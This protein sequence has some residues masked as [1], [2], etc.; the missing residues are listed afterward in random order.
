MKVSPGRFLDYASTHVRALRLLWSASPGGFSL[1]AFLLLLSSLSPPVSIWLV[2]NVVDMAVGGGSV[3]RATLLVGLWAL[4]LLVGQLSTQSMSVLQ[5]HLN[6]AAVGRV[7]TMLLRKANSLPD[8]TLFEN[9]SYYDRLQSLTRE[10]SYRPVNLVVTT[11]QLMS[12]GLTAIGLLVLTGTLAWWLPLVL[13]VTPLPLAYV[14]MRLMQQS[15]QVM[16]RRSRFARLMRYML[17]VLTTDEHAKEVRVFDLGP[18]FEERYR[19][20]FAE[21]HAL[22]QFERLRRLPISLVAVLIF[23]AGGVVTLGWVVSRALV[24]RLSAGSVVLVLQSLLALQQ[25]LGQIVAMLSVLGGHLL[26]FSELFSFLAEPS[27]MRLAEPGVKLVPPLKEGISFERVGY[28]YP[29]GAVALDGVSFEI[30][31]GERVALVGENGAGKSTLVK[32]LCRLHDPTTGA[33]RVDGADLRDLDLGAWRRRIAPVF[34][35]F[36]RYQL[37][38]AENIALGRLEFLDRPE[39]LKHAARDS[40]FEPHLS[41]LADGL[42]TQLGTQFDGVELSHGQ[43]QTLGIARAMIRDADILVLDEPTA[44][45]DPRAEHHLFQRFASLVRGRTAIF[46]THRLASVRMADR[47]LVLKSGKLVEEGTHDDL[48]RLDGEYTELYTLQ[49]E[50]YRPVIEEA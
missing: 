22:N 40:G 21:L 29:G 20:A 19:K 2:M 3:A 47:I 36:G 25:N 16:G 9:S 49:S 8:L 44:A 42:T 50:Q 6:E 5:V 26:Y 34:Q 4:V 7:E 32:L 17:S 35:D 15:W 10:A 30:R 18:F 14:S 39:A 27:P 45:L 11:S 48:M 41:G 31:P 38:A 24:G 23:V 33:I 1:M 37:T 13:L 28:R 12:N 46:V 43:W